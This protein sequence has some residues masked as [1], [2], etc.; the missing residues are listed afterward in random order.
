MR[1]AVIWVT[2]VL[3]VMSGGYLGD[4]MLRGYVEDRLAETINTEVGTQ[5]SSSV[6]LGGFPFVLALITRSVPQAGIAVE[7][8]PLEISGHKVEL[9]A[10]TATT[11]EVRL[12][13]EAVHVATVSGS[14]TLGYEDLAEIA[15]IPIAYAGH[16]RLELRYTKQILGRELSFAVSALPELDVTEQVIRLAAAKLDVAGNDVD[17]DLTQKQLDAIV[18][19]ISVE[20]EHGLRLTSLV[21]AEAGVAIG[22]DGRD[23]TVPIR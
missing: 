22:V 16:G 5:G 19:P 20:L 3:L 4:N 17:L 23:L 9:T 15:E 13:S 18:A 6:S 8:M 12:D 21:P 7:T 11:G 14:A 2:V 1:R 10:V